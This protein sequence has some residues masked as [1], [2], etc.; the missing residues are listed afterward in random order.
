[1]GSNIVISK[2]I[3]KYIDKHS[4]KLHPVQNEIIAYN[5]KLGDIKRNQISISQCHF[6]HLLIKTSSIKKI[7]EIG[8]FTGLS[9]LSMLLALPED[10]KLLTLDKNKNTTAI[11]YNFFKKATLLGKAE[12]IIENALKTIEN[13]KIEN[14]KF[15]LVFIDA[16]KENYKIYYD[17]SLNLIDKNGLI[18]VD[19]VLWHGDVADITKKDKLTRI[20]RE[21]NT[22]VNEDKRTENLIIPLGDGLTICRKL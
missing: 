1:M 22:Y 4:L 13:L 14:E 3:E 19:N 15:D 12:I 11:A 16:D 21:F 5:E 6:L 2:E 7:L 8:T 20:I 9:A 10:G 18:V 17:E